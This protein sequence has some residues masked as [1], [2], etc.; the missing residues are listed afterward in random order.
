MG[1]DKAALADTALPSPAYRQEGAHVAAESLATTN[2]APLGAEG[3]EARA[4][5]QKR[6]A[7]AATALPDCLWAE[8]RTLL[9][10]RWGSK[11][12]IIIIACDNKKIIIGLRTPLSGRHF[13]DAPR[14]AARAA[15]EALGEDQPTAG[16]QHSPKDSCAGWGRGSRCAVGRRVSPLSL[17]ARSARVLPFSSSA[18]S[19]RV[20]P[21][22][23]SARSARVLPLSSSA[24][25][26]RVLP[27][28]SSARS[29]RVLPLSSSARSARVLPLSSS[30]RSARV[31]PKLNS[32]LCLGILLSSIRTKYYSF[33]H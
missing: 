18:R 15:Q 33:P 13:W 2:V 23:S 27:L 30:A 21:F 4:W 9:P 11:T 29:A 10:S 6:A 3:S 12:I 22:S 20:L 26:A 1:K 7:L 8:G 16:R 32:L 19:A 24:R 28:S 25:S 14:G 31:P 5:G 17:S